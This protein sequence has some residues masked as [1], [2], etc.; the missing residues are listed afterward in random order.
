M[1]YFNQQF[2]VDITA[3]AKTTNIPGME[4]QDVAQ[5]LDIALWK[6]LPKFR[7]Q[8]KAHKRTFAWKIMRNRILDLHKASDRQ[9]R[10]LDSHH[11][12]FS[13]LE[14]TM[15]G[16]RYLDSARPIWETD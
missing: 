16:Q 6:G 15:S 10:F 2:S 7:G 12:L 8:N 5:E 13:E 11:L 14:L 3:R 4:W 1:Q 9:K